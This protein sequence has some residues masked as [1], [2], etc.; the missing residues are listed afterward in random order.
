MS[1]AD[2]GVTVSRGVGRLPE[3]A[4]TPGTLSLISQVVER[5]LVSLKDCLVSV[6]CHFHTRCQG[7][8]VLVVFSVTQFWALSVGG[9]FLCT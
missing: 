3:A 6:A 1:G 4:D 8:T 5:S 2:G 9:C 7:F